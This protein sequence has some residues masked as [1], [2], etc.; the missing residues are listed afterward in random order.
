MYYWN[1]NCAAVISR[2]K[3]NKRL[4]LTTVKNEHH[5]TLTM[6]WGRGN[7]YENELFKVSISFIQSEHKVLPWL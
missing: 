3:N 6:V 4:N 5:I 1:I 2:E 7:V